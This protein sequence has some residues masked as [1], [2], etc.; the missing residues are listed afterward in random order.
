M[1]YCGKYRI[2]DQEKIRTYPV[3]ERINKVKIEDFLN[4]SE[5]LKTNYK[6]S[7]DIENK[8]DILSE[9]IIS[10]RKEGKPVIVFTGAH[11]IKNGLSVLIIEMLKMLIII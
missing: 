3:K 8:I 4:P 6:V 9:I 1:K 2:F 11:L 10:H 5:V 7:D